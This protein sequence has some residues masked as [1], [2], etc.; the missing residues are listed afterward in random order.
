M[1]SLA[2]HQ[3]RSFISTFRSSWAQLPAAASLAANLDLRQKSFSWALPGLQSLLELLPPIVLAVPKSKISHSRKSMR[4]ANK[5]L[6]DKRNIVNCPACGE[7][8][9]A[10][11]ACK[12]C[13]SAIMKRFRMETKRLATETTKRMSGG[14]WSEVKVPPMIESPKDS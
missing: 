11:H 9:L 4:S 12:A 2:L 14:S 7:P 6:K 3:T 1:A 13:Y 10:H 8:K 5:G